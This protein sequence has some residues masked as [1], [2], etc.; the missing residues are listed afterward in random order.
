MRPSAK[1]RAKARRVSAERKDIRLSLHA[2]RGPY[3]EGCPVTPV[4][5]SS[6]PRPWTDMHE[7]LTRGRGGDATDPLNILCLCRECHVWVT[8]HE[9]AAR[10]LG[11]V[12]A[13]TAAEHTA[14]FRIMAPRES[15][16]KG[17]IV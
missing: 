3:C 10:A 9:E 8:T 7:I 6:N 13:R 2:A 4:G 12:R 5:D 1:S 17:G 11:L 15:A 16:P 14:L